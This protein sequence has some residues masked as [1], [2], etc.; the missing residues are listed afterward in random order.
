MSNGEA[1]LGSVAGMVHGNPAEIEVT[2]WWTA[3]D[4]GVVIDAPGASIGLEDDKAAA[5]A[6]LL[7]KGAVGYNGQD[8]PVVTG[9]PLAEFLASIEKDL[10]D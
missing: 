8:A 3:G 10:A 2:Q 1:G 9:V 7:I 6:R 4:S 5:L